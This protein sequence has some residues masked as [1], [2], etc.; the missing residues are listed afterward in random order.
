MVVDARV[1][2]A[3]AGIFP[4][5]RRSAMRAAIEESVERAIERTVDDHRPVAD[6]H[7][8]EVAGFRNLGVEAEVTPDR[9]AKYPFLFALED[10]EIAEYGVGHA[11]EV[12]RRP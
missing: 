9:P 8:L 6:E 11:A 5:Q 12:G 2:F 1:V 3:V 10:V 4:H 7:S